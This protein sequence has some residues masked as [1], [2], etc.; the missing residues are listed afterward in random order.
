MAQITD[1]VRALLSHPLI[2]SSFQALMGPRSIRRNFVADFVKPEPGMS[3]LD[4]GCGPADIL[5]YLPAVDYRGFDISDAY[6]QHA[7]KRFG[8]RGRFACKLLEAGDL[9]ALPK[10]DVVLALGLIHHLDDAEAIAMMRLAVA[11][12]KPGGR[13]ITI[14][15]VLD[16]KQNLIARFLVRRDRGQNVRDK[17]GYESLASELF[18]SLRIEV[19]HQAWIPYTHCMME[20][21]TGG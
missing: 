19:R 11:A 7:Q 20:C 10:F 16:A 5:D 15:P 12:L 8:S 1:G 18:S 17:I 14:D 9:A 6:I 3:V 4:I 21:T 13:L 2:Y